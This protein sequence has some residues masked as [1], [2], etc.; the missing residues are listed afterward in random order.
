M[1]DRKYTIMATICDTLEFLSNI[2]DNITDVNKELFSF[3]DKVAEQIQK[4]IKGILAQL[5]CIGNNKRF[6]EEQLKELKDKL[7]NDESIEAGDFL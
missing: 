6:A 7:I 4:Q 1:T 3:D 5:N 2:D